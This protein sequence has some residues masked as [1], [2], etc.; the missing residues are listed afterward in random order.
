MLDKSALK[1]YKGRTVAKVF[2]GYG[3]EPFRG[4]V[5]RGSA[6][7]STS[8]E[9]RACAAPFAPHPPDRRPRGRPE[10]GG[11]RA[12]A[13]PR[14]TVAGGSLHLPRRPARS[15]AAD[16]RPAALG[17]ALPACGRV[18]PPSKPRPPTPQV[19]T[20]DYKA[21]DGKPFKARRAP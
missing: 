15:G 11:G 18:P 8:G 3:T 10:A 20:V 9:A 2:E 21:T 4:T 6:Q 14:P 5:R 16:P 19:S 7:R 1:A 17:G 12:R 13:S